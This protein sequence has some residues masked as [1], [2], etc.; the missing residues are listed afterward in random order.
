MW[1]IVWWYLK[2]VYGGF[3]SKVV[4]L[5]HEVT[6]GLF[7]L[8]SPFDPCSDGHGFRVSLFQLSESV[9]NNGYCGWVGVVCSLKSVE[10]IGE[11]FY[12]FESFCFGD[13]SCLLTIGSD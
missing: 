5:S 10:S 6:S 12:A 9:C 11:I 8:F 2:G 13:S 7:S 1:C 4:E 3:V